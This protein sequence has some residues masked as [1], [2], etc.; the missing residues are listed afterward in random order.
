M[1]L[2]V[3]DSKSSNTILDAGD[4]KTKARSQEPFSKLTELFVVNLARN[5][6]GDD[7]ASLRSLTLCAKRFPPIMD[8]TYLI[9]PFSI[10]SI[11]S[12]QWKK[13]LER[14]THVQTLKARTEWNCD[15]VQ[16]LMD[17][18]LF[19]RMSRLDYSSN[20]FDEKGRSLRSKLTELVLARPQLTR[21]RGMLQEEALEALCDRDLEEL[22]LGNFYDTN[23]TPEELER[24]FKR[25]KAPEK[26]RKILI[27]SKFNDQHLDVIV[28]YLKGLE[29]VSFIRVSGV[30]GNGMI[31]F[32][33]NNKQL[34]RLFYCE[35]FTFPLS[36]PIFTAITQNCL[37]LNAFSC[38]LESLNGDFFS[39]IM[40]LLPRLTTLRFEGDLIGFSSM[41]SESS[42]PNL[43]SLSLCSYNCS[44]S[45][46]LFDAI[47]N[48]CTNLKYLSIEVFG[49]NYNLDMYGVSLPSLKYLQVSGRN[50]SDQFLDQIP[51]LY[52][53]LIYLSF[54]RCELSNFTN[55]GLKRLSENCKSLHYLEV[56]E[57]VLGDKEEIKKIFPHLRGLR[58][59]P[60]DPHFN[61]EV[62]NDNRWNERNVLFTS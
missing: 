49:C 50:L 41:L 3:A 40:G 55:E 32:F 20:F 28:R 11:Q 1:T 46:G 7:P 62:L 13:R 34:R 59:S 22:H 27:T 6:L 4:S 36:E 44:T 35:D 30:T 5:Y 31:R 57:G 42:L 18:T 2:T 38:N 29:E 53:T 23:I 39:N 56:I 61:D 9:L 48:K 21:V 15:I 37:S 51:K 33:E 26:L 60:L 17:R 8:P 52:P 54:G 12:D 10:P 24:C 43:R 16:M 45:S 58:T 14:F 19:P 25:L 47:K